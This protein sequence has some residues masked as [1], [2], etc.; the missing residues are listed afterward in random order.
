MNV[1]WNGCTVLFG[2]QMTLFP[3][4]T[5]FEQLG[6]HP[7]CLVSSFVC[8]TWLLA[9]KKSTPRAHDWLELSQVQDH[10]ISC[11]LFTCSSLLFFRCDGKDLFF[12]LGALSNWRTPRVSS[13]S[14]VKVPVVVVLVDGGSCGFS[15][16]SFKSA[17]CCWFFLLTFDEGPSSC[18][19][20]MAGLVDGDSWMRLSEFK[21]KYK[22]H[23]ISIANVSWGWNNW[24]TKNRQT[25][26][27]AVKQQQQQ[28]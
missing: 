8:S 19:L 7:S 10:F 2:K 4:Q 14:K 22:L 6:I 3:Q 23:Y 28:Q 17:S 5:Y 27:V 26:A 12:S 16:L 21:G 1:L 11:H 24:I 25:E 15:V 9:I 18:D 20:T 13:A